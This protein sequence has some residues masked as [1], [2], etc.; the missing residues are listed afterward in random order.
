MRRSLLALL[1]LISACS[2]GPEAPPI[3]ATEV[4][5]A[6]EFCIAYPGGWEAEVGDTF[7]SFRH[8]LAPESALATIGFTNPEAVVTSAG[9]TWPANSETV[10]RAFWALLEETDVASFERLERLPGGN[11]RSYGSYQDGRMW[12]LLVPTDEARAV[13][14][15]VRAPNRG[16]ESHADVFFSSVEL[17]P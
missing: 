7:I 4:A 3:T 10:A 16:W 12:T 2:S 11:I 8:P 6:P 14:V 13:G 5:C 15:E 1:I 9:E 17:V